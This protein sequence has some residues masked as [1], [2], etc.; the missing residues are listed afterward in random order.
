MSTA[1]ERISRMFNMGKYGETLAQEI[2]DQHTT[3]LVE[4]QR[5]WVDCSAD[6]R[7]YLS[8]DHYLLGHAVIDLIDPKAGADEDDH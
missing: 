7:Q 5:R 3:E 2:L 6:F 4:V 8:Q 1:H